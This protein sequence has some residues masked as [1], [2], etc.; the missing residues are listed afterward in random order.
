MPEWGCWREMAAKNGAVG[1]IS[2]E[3]Q[4]LR[5]VNDGLKTVSSTPN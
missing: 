2:Q 4:I 5:I 3:L 1:A